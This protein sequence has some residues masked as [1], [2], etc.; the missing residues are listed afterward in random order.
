M[1]KSTHIENIA[2]ENI[3]FEDASKE[4]E[5]I[6]AKMESG[7]LSLQDSIE[8]YERGAELLAYCQSRLV[9]AEQKIQLLNAANQLED[10]IDRDE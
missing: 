3:S 4:L 10:Y 1:K 5:A 8:A 2:S 6:V 9:N 7:K